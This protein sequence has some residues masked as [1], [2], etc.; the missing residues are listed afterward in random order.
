MRFSR[1]KVERPEWVCTYEWV[2][3][4]PIEGAWFWTLYLIHDDVLGKLE[5]GVAFSRLGIYWQ[6]WR[7]CR[8]H[9]L[10]FHI[11]IRGEIPA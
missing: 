3:A 2:Q 6:V 11:N 4:T 8:K 7:L 1:R 5:E 9:G 10:G